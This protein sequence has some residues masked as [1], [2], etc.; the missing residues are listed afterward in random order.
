MSLAWR[1]N[2]TKSG[3]ALMLKLIDGI[4]SNGKAGLIDLNLLQEQ[5]VLDCLLYTSRCV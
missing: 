1:F 3:D 5:K 2:G 4:L